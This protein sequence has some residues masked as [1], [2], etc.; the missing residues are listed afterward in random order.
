[1]VIFSNFSVY[2]PGRVWISVD[3]LISKSKHVWGH[4]KTCILVIEKKWVVAGQAHNSTNKGK[5]STF[6][7]NTHP[8]ATS[9]Q[10]I[11]IWITTVLFQLASSQIW[12]HI[13]ALPENQGGPVLS[14]F[15]F[16]LLRPGWLLN[17][18][19]CAE[20]KPSLIFRKWANSPDTSNLRCF[21]LF[22]DHIIPAD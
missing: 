22:K 7:G 4:R 11:P 10:C 20:Q 2:P 19:E 12:I 21:A 6:R 17:A 5:K 18:N 1:M 16:A 9:L 3:C 8:L 13:L 15:I 14:I